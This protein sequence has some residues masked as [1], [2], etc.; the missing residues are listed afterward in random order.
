[1]IE[2]F[3][4]NVLSPPILFFILGISAGLLRSDL[5]V[6]EQISRYL[7]IYLMMAIGFKGG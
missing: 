3:L 4:H 5:Q 7:S 1:M 2:L 6:P